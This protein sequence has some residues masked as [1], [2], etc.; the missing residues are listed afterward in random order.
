MLFV[1]ANPI[2]LIYELG[3]FHNDVF[4][5]LPALA[6]IPLFRST[7]ATAR[8]PAS[9]MLAVAIKFTAVLLLPFLLL[10]AR[11]ARRRIWLLAGMVLAAVPLAAASHHAFGNRESEP[12]QPQPAADDVQ[13]AEHRRPRAWPRRRHT[14]AAAARGHRGGRRRGRA[15]REARGLG[16]GSRVVDL[17]LLCSLAWL[18]PWYIVWL[19]PLAA[20]GTSIRLRR[21]ALVFTVFLVLTFLPATTMF[22]A[23]HHIDPLATS[24]GQ[25]SQAL[26]RKLEQQPAAVSA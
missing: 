4:M 26:Q 11:P 13:R 3:G 16:H 6:S 20:L 23:V 8:G 12:V 25:A 18:V 7:G 22:L 5:L 1:A 10:A 21:A 2:F 15:R 19:L 17:A 24:A 9:L 14:Y